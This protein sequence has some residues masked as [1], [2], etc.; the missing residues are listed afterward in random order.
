LY[1][2]S[3]APPLLELIGAAARSPSWRSRH[4][5]LRANNSWS[6][7]LFHVA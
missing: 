6:E 3:G 2:I 7:R 1:A 4:D 5:A